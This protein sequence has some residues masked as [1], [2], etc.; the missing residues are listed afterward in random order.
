MLTVLACACAGSGTPTGPEAAAGAGNGPVASQGGGSGSGTV[1]PGGGSSGNP[2]NPA[3]AGGGAESSSSAGSSN[4]T[5]GGGGAGGSAAGAAGTET[6]G[7]AAEQA[8]A[9]GASGF[10]PLFDG[11]SLDGFTA[12]REPATT[13]TPAEAA[14]IF[15]V[16][17]GAIRVYG[18]AADQSTQARHTLLTSKSFSNYKLSLQYKW[19][20]K[21][22][23][24]YTDLV[25]YPRDAGLLFHVH[26]DVHQVWPSSI[27]FQIKDGSTGDIFALYAQ[28][29]AL[30]KN[31]GTTFVDAA[32][33]GTPKLV[34][35]S[36]GFVQHARSANFEVAG[37]N[38]ILLEVEAG[39][40]TYTVNGHVVNRVV[41]VMDKQG[42]AVTSGPVALQA[43]HAEVFY[44]NVS[45]LELP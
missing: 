7:Q 30:G 34:D 25:K 16:E 1:N 27:E 3:S 15:K 14:T 19:G 18:D 33:G 22:F 39:A 40:A 45:I 13:L 9:A 8:G 31:G 37:W 26:G 11:K 32:D 42:K 2:A 23:A 35:G 43:E 28:C 41:K 36:T 10:R 21:K 24:P 4:A 6:G 38:D 17:D 29:T 20:T 5:S 12:Y 44:R